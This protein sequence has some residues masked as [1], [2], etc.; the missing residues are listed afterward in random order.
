MCAD[1]I[2]AEWLGSFKLENRRA[3]LSLYRHEHKRHKDFRVEL[4]EPLMSDNTR[5]CF[6]GR[7]SG[8]Q[9]GMLITQNHQYSPTGQ[10]F[11]VEF[12]CFLEFR[13]QQIV[14]AIYGYNPA[15]V[16]VQLGHIEPL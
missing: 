12:L 5:T 16:L 4:V 6:R 3:F 11:S 7:V 1:G 14:R 13:S 9:I 15:A 8:T 2:E 10:S